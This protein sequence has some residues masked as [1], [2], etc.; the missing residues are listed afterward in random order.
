MTDIPY[1]FMNGCRKAILSQYCTSR[2]EW[3]NMRNATRARRG[4]STTHGIAVYAHDHRGHGDAVKSHE[5]LG[6][7]GED[8]FVKKVNDLRYLIKL[9][10]EKTHR[11]ENISAR[12]QHGLLHQ[13]VFFSALRK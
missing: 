2:T 10:K 11:E 13:P 8:S 12:T 1:L 6:F 7:S 9:E 5:D 3:Q 4:F